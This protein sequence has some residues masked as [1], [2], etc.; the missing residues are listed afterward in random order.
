MSTNKY[1]KLSRNEML[2]LAGGAKKWVFVSRVVVESKCV[3]TDENGNCMIEWVV[4]QET[5]QRV[6]SHGDILQTE[7]R[8]D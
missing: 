3:K 4:T 8:P 7:Y 2:K 6:N 1:Q 5:W